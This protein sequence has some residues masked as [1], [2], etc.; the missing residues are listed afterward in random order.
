M[1]N[2]I[3]KSWQ[4]EP[5]AILAAVNIL[6]ESIVVLVVAFG[7]SL[8]EMQIAAILGV[9]NAILGVVTAL[10][11]RSQVTPLSKSPPSYYR[12]QR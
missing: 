6:V 4:S 1:W 10:I 9:T 11:G 8:S 2:L 3:L 7:L 12:S 5:L